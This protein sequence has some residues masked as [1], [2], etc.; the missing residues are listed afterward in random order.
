MNAVIA[1][2]A[3][4][5]K[6]EALDGPAFTTSR[7]LTFLYRPAEASGLANFLHNLSEGQTN[8]QLAIAVAWSPEGQA[9]HNLLRGLRRA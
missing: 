2:A 4:W 1:P 7:H 9:R 8:L 6:L 3:D 5:G